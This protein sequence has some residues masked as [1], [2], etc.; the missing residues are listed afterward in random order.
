MIFKDL[1]SNQAKDYALFRP[2]YPQELFDFLLSLTPKRDFAWD[3][4]TGNGQA[5]KVLAQ[6]FTKVWA[7]DASQAQIQEG[8]AL[9]NI[10]YQVAT[11][12]NSLLADHSCQLITVAQAIHWFDFDK[13]YAEVERVAQK[14]GILAIWGYGLLR[15]SPEIDAIIEQFYFEDMGG[16]WDAE[17]KHLDNAYSTIPFPYPLLPS[18]ALMMRKEWNLAT[19]L[20]YLFTWSSVQKYIKQHQHNPLEKVAIALE[21]IWGNPLTPKSIGWDLY[22]KVGKV[23]PS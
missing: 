9:P 23:N 6:Y 15:I 10:T 22:L 1:F 2:D 4:A 13:F 3:C 11:A 12:E 5:A 16:Y 20:Q 14:D 17:R 19:L 21:K 18:P 8:F 7:T